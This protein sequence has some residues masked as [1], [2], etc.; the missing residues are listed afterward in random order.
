M[1]FPDGD[2]NP[3]DRIPEMLAG[4]A[5]SDRAALAVYCNAWSCYT[6]SLTAP[7]DAATVM[8]LAA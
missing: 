4:L 1:T 5:D 6:D 2:G 3:A 7:S 8:E